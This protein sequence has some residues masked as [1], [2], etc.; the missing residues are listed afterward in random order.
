MTFY[1]QKNLFRIHNFH[2]SS[3]DFLQT[4]LNHSEALPEV[5]RNSRY[6]IIDSDITS[7]FI[8]ILCNGNWSCCYKSM[9]VD[10]ILNGLT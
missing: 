4:P 5:Q 9:E 6:I 8:F 7:T 2:H 10:V 3:L 1:I